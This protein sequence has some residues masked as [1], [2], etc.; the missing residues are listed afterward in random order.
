MGIGLNGRVKL[1]VPKPAAQAPPQPKDEPVRDIK[2]TIKTKDTAYRKVEVVI[3]PFKSKALGANNLKTTPRKPQ[4]FPLDLGKE[5]CLVEA[6][7][8][9]GL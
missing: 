3:P 5:V 9:T 2:G 6:Y 7:Y 4:A 8:C 1:T